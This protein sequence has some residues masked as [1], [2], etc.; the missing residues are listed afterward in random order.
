MKGKVD[1]FCGI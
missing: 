1:N